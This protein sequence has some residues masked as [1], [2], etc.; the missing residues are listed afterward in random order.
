[1]LE[2]IFKKYPPGGMFND[3]SFVRG[4][5]DVC[6]EI[7]YNDKEIKNPCKEYTLYRKLVAL[8]HPQNILDK[9]NYT[10]LKEEYVRHNV[11]EGED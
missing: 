2:F 5:N 9:M 10:Q 3:L 7:G 11:E 4:I 1:M 6:K 8:G